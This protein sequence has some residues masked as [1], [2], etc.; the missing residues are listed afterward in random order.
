MNNACSSFS[1]HF[2]L[3]VLLASVAAACSEDFT[4]PEAVAEVRVE[5]ASDSVWVGSRLQLTARVLDRAGEEVNGA[6]V[7]WSSSDTL[8]ATVDN[9]GEVTGVSVGRVTIRAESGGVSGSA[10][11]DVKP[12]PPPEITES[13]FAWSQGAESC[14]SGFQDGLTRHGFRFTSQVRPDNESSE[15]QLQ[16]RSGGAGRVTSWGSYDFDF[17]WGFERRGGSWHGTTGTEACWKLG[18]D[19]EWIEERIRIR[20][21]TAGLWSD[22]KEKRLE[23]DDRSNLYVEHVGSGAETSDSPELETRPVP[24]QDISRPNEL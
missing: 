4:S 14:A 13:Q 19:V 23:V 3:V 7:E 2:V 6:S 8:R 16:V 22:W 10:R 24:L 9:D 17:E 11:I 12:P 18:R 21:E 1:W 5:P 20:I 15:V